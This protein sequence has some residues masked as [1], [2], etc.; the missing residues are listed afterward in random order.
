M[1]SRRDLARLF[2]LI[3]RTGKGVCQWSNIE[4]IGLDDLRQTPIGSGPY[5]VSRYVGDVGWTLT[6][7]P[8]YYDKDGYYIETIERPILPEY[9]A[10]LAQFRTGATYEAPRMRAE[11]VLPT[12]R[13]VPALELYQ[14]DVA[15]SVRSIFFGWKPN[16]PER[17]P[18][19]D[20]RTPGL[21]DGTEPGRLP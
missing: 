8:G 3:S 2:G 14:T 15:G 7:N 5:Y 1:H 17:T 6:R 21:F 13:A 4:N 10:S 9:A 19:R 20:E 16:P 12:K 18:F 11:D